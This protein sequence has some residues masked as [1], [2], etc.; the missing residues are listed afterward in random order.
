MVDQ[1]NLLPSL[2]LHH[3][4][5]KTSDFSGEVE[6]A[7]LRGVSQIAAR[8]LSG[9]ST[10]ARRDD[11]L[12]THHQSSGWVVKKPSAGGCPRCPTVVFPLDG[13]RKSL[14]PARMASKS[15]RTSGIT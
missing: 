8:P 6:D 15:I 5:F 2:F 11:R 14:P 9:E 10:P 13:T 4:S 1:P 3:K 12:V 7:R